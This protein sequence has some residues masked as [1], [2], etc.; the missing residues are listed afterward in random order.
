MPFTNRIRLPF[1]TNKA[2]F[3]TERNVFRRADGSTKV[4][5]AVVRN[6]YQ[7]LTDYLPEKWHKRLVIALNH[8]DVTIENDHYLGG[9]TLDADYSIDW[10]EFQNYPVAQ[11][12]TTVEVT[13]FDATNSNC[14]TC[15]QALQISLKDDSF[16]T[17][18]NEGT[19]HTLDVAQNDS[20]CC[21]P[22]LFEVVSFN[23]DFIQSASFTGN[24]LSVTLNPAT[25]DGNSIKVV[26][27]RVTCPDGSYDEADVYANI[28]GTEAVCNP[29]GQPT[30][31]VNNFTGGSSGWPAS[32]PP[33][34]TY[35]WAVVLASNPSV[36]LSSGNTDAL[37]AAYTGLTAGTDY[38]FIVN[39]NC[40]GG[41]R[42]ATVSQPFTTPAV[43][44]SN[45]CGKFLIYPSGIS[46]PTNL[47]YKDC[48]GSIQTIT[49][50][51]FFSTE[52]CM[53]QKL[54]GVPD[55]FT[56]VGGGLSY[57]YLGLC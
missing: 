31:L 27:Y 15:E 28:N 38:I 29:P 16:N 20:I 49:I 47:T 52:I 55:T 43:P 44:A 50:V 53:L 14:Q 10:L 34:S 36:I 57:D 21:Y 24:I 3:P 9:I 19:T 42:S 54:P 4:L 56:A 40:G 51:P 17:T 32:V 45:S 48:A 37:T 1:M 39:S 35:D 8:D 18:L 26:T 13:P 11:G 25:A 7:L 46:T 22:A 30:I 5:S 41:Q 12:T 23:T 33:S 2:Q 6:T